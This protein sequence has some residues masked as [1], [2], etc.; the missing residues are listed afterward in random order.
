MEKTY[1]PVAIEE[2]CYAAWEE[3]GCFQPDGEGAPY[4]IML[5][6]PNVTGSLH[7]GHAFQGTLI[8][9]LIRYHRMQQHRTL[10]QGGTDHAG[11][12]TQTVVERQLH[13]Q[14]KIS[15][16]E[17][18]RDKF[19]EKVWQWK[20]QSGQTI[21]RQL[22]RLGASIDWQ[23]ERFTL[24]EK[25]SQAVN[26]C[27]IHL[28]KKGL[29]YR[30][31]RLVNWDPV[32]RTAISDLEVLNQEEDGWLWHIAYPFS[33]GDGHLEVVTT[34]PETLLA[35]AAVAIHPDDERYQAH[36]GRHLSLPLSGR[37]IKVIADTYVDAQFGS[38]CVK[39]TPAHDFNDYTV[40]QRHHLPLINILNPDA[41]LN[42]QVPA[43][44][45]G[46][47]RYEARA[48]VVADLEA[49]GLLIKKERHRLSVP[50]GD[51]S[52]AVIEPFLTEQW[53]VRAQPLAQAA[54]RAVEEK[55]TR[56]VP[57]GWEKTYFDW[58][59]NI[60]DWCI[61]RQ[62][63]WG[64]RIPAWYDSHQRVYVGCD[65][66][67][68]RQ[69]HKLPD[70]EQ[71]RQDEDVLDTWF[72]SA[73][74]PFSTLGWPHGNQDLRDFYPGN[75]L[76][77]GF[78][79]IFFWV[80]RM[81]MMGIE[82]MEEVP[83]R[84]VYVHGLVRDAEGQKM[85][86]S[87]GNVL[88]PIDLMDG[89][90]LESLVRKRV[91]AIMQPQHAKKAEK[92]TRQ[93]FPQGIP[94]YG[95]DAL[96]FTFMA[97]ASG[98]R[99]IRFDLKRIEGY[100]NFCNKLWN[101]A[102]FVI[103]SCEGKN[104]ATAGAGHAIDEWIQQRL[105]KTISN[106]H[107]AMA[108]YRFDQLANCLYE[109][110]WHDYCDWFLEFSKIVQHNEGCVAE[111][112]RHRHCLLHTLETILRLLHPIIPF[113]SE[114]IWQ[115]LKPLTG[116]HA[117]SIQQRPYPRAQEQIRP[118]SEG[119]AITWVQEVI[120]CVR[121]L[122]AENRLPPQ[123]VLPVMVQAWNQQQ[124]LLWQQHGHLIEK[125]ARTEPPVWLSDKETPPASAMSLVGQ[126]KLYVP[127]AGLIDLDSEAQRLQKKIERLEQQ[128]QR[129]QQSF[130][131]AGFIA[132]APSEVVAQQ[133]QQLDDMQAQIKKLQS[134][135]RS[136]H[137]A[138]N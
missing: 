98:G 68:V 5:P 73:L 138:K 77:T 132:N 126:L 11:I 9:C 47:D 58:L 52:H 50:R 94:A 8:D 1:Q 100:R 115:K 53:F 80:A 90:D 113:I 45:R 39:I 79:I 55:R 63:W 66:A 92:M 91:A 131:K 30:G 75:V 125:L 109:F 76:V 12:A 112:A 105:N 107:Q 19:I 48:R 130:S 120:H 96:R 17:L 64:H 81:M 78:D 95:A 54:I 121:T 46:L 118:S 21:S 104:L 108:D 2:R 136:L 59:H 35:D 36:L 124:Q 49:A 4:C 10:W 93:Q 83:F 84:T 106:A 137:Q 29:I 13:A 72:S 88:D 42:E 114:E 33:D 28:Y 31:Q 62:L 15:R 25:M 67:T 6:P 133:R 57:R 56:F 97:M 103:M 127:L 27:F 32:L 44:Y 82:F 22:R 74:W 117:S 102:R 69:Q 123:K 51:R 122:R 128:W 99:D 71:L 40:G 26:Q 41:S 37:Q 134:Q 65:E 87:K 60:E 3:S 110:V 34:R 18:G 16:H 61:S 135:Y 101:A 38:G 116:W 70:G 23:R 129:R 119:Q 86:K 20:A 111:H 14:E 85:S 89:I 24:D 7:M 43:A